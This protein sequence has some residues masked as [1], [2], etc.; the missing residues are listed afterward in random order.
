MDGAGRNCLDAELEDEVACWVY[1]MRQKMLHVSRKIIMFKPNKIFDDKTTDPASR[2][3]FVANGGWCEK[4]M[5]HHGFSLRRKTTT[6]QKDPSYLIDRLVSFVMHG[7]QLQRQYNFVP[8]NI[9]T[10]DETAVWNDMV[11]ETTV[12]ATSAKDVPMKSTGHEKVRVSVCL[13]ANLDGT[14]LKS[15]IVFGAATR[16]WKSLHN[17]YKRRCS[18]ASSSN[19]WMKEELTLRWCD[20]VLGQFIFQKRLLAGDSFEAHITDEVKRKLTTSKAESLIVPGDFTKYIQIPDLLWNK[21]FKA[22]KFKNFA[23]TG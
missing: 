21:P 20:E 6:A 12:K 1:S 15:F 10:V 8:H 2:D 18:V 7:C 14:K 9:V 5:R 22:N 23:M 17:E 16:E 11:F 13:A 19:A 4:F 3:A